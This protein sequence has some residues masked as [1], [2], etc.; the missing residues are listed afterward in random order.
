MHA[1]FEGGEGCG[2]DVCDERRN[3]PSI[4]ED[5]RKSD[6]D[7]RTLVNILRSTKYIYKY[8][9]KRI[10]RH[11]ALVIPPEGPGMGLCPVK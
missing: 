5:A 3:M 11:L 2:V 9:R 6:K 1:C 7:V 10:Q 8:I 4:A